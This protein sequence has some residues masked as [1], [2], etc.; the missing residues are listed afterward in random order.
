ML[1]RWIDAAASRIGFVPREQAMT[2]ARNFA[3]G[4]VSRLTS[5]WSTSDI[6]FN[7]SLFSS[8]SGMR[9]HSRELAR[10]NEY[11]KRF[12]SMV[13]TNVAGPD[14]FTLQSRAADVGADGKSRPDNVANAIIEREWE[15]W[16]K[17]GICEITGRM[18][19]CDVDRLY[20]RTLA[21]D[22]EVLIKR[23]RGA[24][25]RWGYTLQFLDVARL[26][27][28][29]NED[30]ANGNVV[31]MSVEMDRSARPV[32]YWLRK[33]TPMPVS[34][35]AWTGERERIPAED[36]WHDFIVHDPEQIRGLPWMH[37]AMV[38]LWQEGKFEEAA[39]VAAR[40]GASKVG[41][42][43]SPTGEPPENIATGKDSA[44][45][46]LTD[47]EA[48]QYWTLPTGYE[49]KSW[50]PSYPSDTFDPFVKACLRGI[51]SGLNVSYVSLANDLEGVNFSSIRQGVLDERE[52]WKALQNFVAGGFLSAIY[53]D[54]METS[55]L[56][57]ALGPLPASKLEKFN[58]PQWKPKRWPWVDPLKDMEASVLGINNALR[59]RTDVVAD[60]GD[61]FEDVI[62]QLA[63]E[64]EMADKAGVKLPDPNAPKA[65]APIN[66]DEVNT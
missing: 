62:A 38:K 26:D 32:A 63:A 49:L 29:Y 21:R 55:L 9:A 46:F 64:Q 44:G 14:G 59:T 13:E 40:V 17:R 6:A 10:N 12:L 45:N 61:D 54:W 28:R 65:P 52:A 47:S 2:A 15:R 37:A 16:G 27:E 66:Q 18:G 39:V 8:L 4:E 11:A 22:G 51:A 33:R 43:Q 56:K 36:I 53:T 19:R 23:V 35:Y 50:D 1:R 3:A 20:V 24:S 34:G 7:A 57:R 25:N 60:A 41:V 42:I 30:L 5:S 58:A 48:G 31:R